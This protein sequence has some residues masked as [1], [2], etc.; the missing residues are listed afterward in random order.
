MSKRFQVV[1][2][3][4]P[5]I[6]KRFL[7]FKG[8]KTIVYPDKRFE[9]KKK[10]PSLADFWRKLFDDFSYPVCPNCDIDLQMKDA[11]I[12]NYIPISH[13]LGSRRTFVNPAPPDIT[14]TFECPSCGTKISGKVDYLDFSEDCFFANTFVIGETELGIPKGKKSKR[15]H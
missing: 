4:G 3:S 8:I 2:I 13:T 7:R 15:K 14:M 9:G 12:S 10:E 6:G 5:M 11:E 1:R